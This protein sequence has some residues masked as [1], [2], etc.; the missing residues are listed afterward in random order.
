MSLIKIKR[1]AV[2]GKV[3][4][5]TDLELGELAINTYDGKLFLKKSVAGANT[6]VDV[7]AAYGT[8]YTKTS[9]VATAGQTS[10]SATYTAGFVDVWLNGLKLLASVDYTATNGTTVVLT[11]GAALNDEIE[12]IAWNAIP[13]SNG[14]YSNVTLSGAITEDVDTTTYASVSGT[15]ALSADAGTVQ[16][17]TLSGNVTSVTSSLTSGQYITVMVADGTAYTIAWGT[18]VV[19]VGGTAPTL[20]TT[21]YSVLEFWKVGSVVYGAFVGNVA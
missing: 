21:G 14:T 4:L 2:S 13:I 3:P 5:D 17:W 15:V 12:I 11:T 10:F 20:A 7:T 9:Y 18:T 6:I 19:W 1:S 8:T 16:V